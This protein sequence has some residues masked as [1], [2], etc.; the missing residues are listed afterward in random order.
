M[1]TAAL[2]LVVASALL[3]AVWNLLLKRARDRVAFVW[4]YLLVPLVLFSPAALLS[5]GGWEAATA[6]RSIACGVASGVLQAA[7][8]LAMASAYEHGDL[9]AAYPLSRGAA[10]I[11]I[12]ALGMALLRERVS[13]L[14]FGAIGLMV[15]GVYV[16]SMPSLS[17]GAL[18]EPF[19]A[20]SH[21]SARA[22]LGAGLAIA[23]YHLTDRVGVQGAN[24]VHYILLL[25]AADLCAVTLFVALRHDWGRVRA[26]WRLNC[27]SIVAAGVISLVSYLLVLYALSRERVTYVGP[28]RNLGI[29]FSVLLGALFLGERHTPMR[30]AGSAFIVAGIAVAAAAG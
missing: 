8:L 15:A 25:F 6:L 2:L 3:H 24:H 5:T 27:R 19:R 23:L 12:V 13:A 1:Q 7:C 11:L 9:S 14:G 21:R 22:A 26:E 16:A 29:V 4:W 17:R 10:Q 18:L 20:L 28:A 30:L